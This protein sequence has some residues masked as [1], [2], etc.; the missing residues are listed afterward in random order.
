MRNVSYGEAIHEA[1]IQEME[2]DPSVFVYGLGVDDPLGIYGTTKDLHKRFGADR[3]FDTPLSE[4]AMTGVGVG[5]ALAGMRPVHVHQRM[6]FLLLCMNQLVNMA[7]KKGYMFPGSVSV[8]MVVRAVIGRSWGQG[9]QHSQALHAYFMHIPG[10]RVVAPTTP[11]DVKGALITSIRDNNPVIFMEHRMLYK[12]KGGV[13]SELYASPLG[14]ARILREGKDVTIV[15]IS[16]MVVET[17]RAANYL[18]HKGISAEIIDPIWLSPLDIN[19]IVESV[20]KTGHLLVV[21]HSWLPCGASSEI[22]CQV[23]ENCQNKGIPVQAKRMGYAFAPCPTTR[24]LELE[25][26]PNGQTIAAT[27]YALIKGKDAGWMPEYQEQQ[28]IKEFK[29][30]F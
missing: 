8:P 17:L 5:A 26:Y 18:G 14:K 16:H 22:M 15:G 28:E 13:P 19:T 10:I 27:A 11:Y 6:D 30:P 20:T 1:L 21:D 24:C 23:I 7:S 3:N 9:A 12:N 2:R 25:F 4:D 29:G